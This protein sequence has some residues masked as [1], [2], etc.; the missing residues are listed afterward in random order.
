MTRNSISK[1]ETMKSEQE[2]H[3]SGR[4]DFR[5]RSGKEKINKEITVF[6]TEP[7]PGASCEAIAPRQAWPQKGDCG[8]GL[9]HQQPR[10]LWPV[11]GQLHDAH[12]S[13][14]SSAFGRRASRAD[15]RG[16]VLA[17]SAL[18]RR[19]GPHC[20]YLPSEDSICGQ[21]RGCRVTRQRTG[22]AKQEREVGEGQGLLAWRSRGA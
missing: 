5:A 10:K 7:A 13:K 19:S 20:L 15:H 2:Q 3:H 17:G 22:F 16:A 18:T 11:R 9:G 12:F 8:P 6:S 1:D 14:H 21:P 4:P